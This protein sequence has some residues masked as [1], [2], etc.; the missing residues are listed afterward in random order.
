MAQSK[1]VADKGGSSAFSL[2]E[3]RTSTVGDSSNSVVAIAV[4]RII[5]ILEK[6]LGWARGGKRRCVE[7]LSL[8][9]WKQW[10]SGMMEVGRMRIYKGQTKA[11]GKAEERQGQKG[12]M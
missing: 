2:P 1:R 4:T 12:G 7:L 9:L 8:W 11:V 6:T 5:V 10:T 3:E